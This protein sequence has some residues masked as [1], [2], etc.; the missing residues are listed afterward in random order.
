MTINEWQ[1]VNLFLPAIL[2]LFLL[3]V[4]ML[5]HLGPTQRI[6]ANPWASVKDGQLS[7]VALGMC[8]A[9]FYELRHPAPLVAVHADYQTL[10]TYVLLMGMLGSAVYAAFSPVFP[11]PPAHISGVRAWLFHHRVFVI[12]VALVLGAGVV[13]NE[14]HEL[15]Q[16]EKRLPTSSKMP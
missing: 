3:G 1:W 8:T 14:V 13:Y 5:F 12:S 15:T 16:V 7:W 4:V 2:P 10:Y 11:T 6:Q 9:A